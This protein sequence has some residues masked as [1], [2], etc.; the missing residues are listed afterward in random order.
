VADVEL[1]LLGSALT[2]AGSI[3]VQGIAEKLTRRR[4]RDDRRERWAM[5]NSRLQRDDLVQLQDALIAVHEAEERW[6][7]EC[8]SFL[9]KQLGDGPLGPETK[10]PTF[11]LLGA[12]TMMPFNPFR[13]HADVQRLRLRVEDDEL[14]EL[15]ASLLAAYVATRTAMQNLKPFLGHLKEA[16]ALREQATERLGVLIR[17]MNRPEY[18]ASAASS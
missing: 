6:R 8:S 9:A 1:I 13:S 3:T 11:G 16:E 7:M 5:E 12:L 15:V 18:L 4:D 14:R 17:S 2:L 10:A